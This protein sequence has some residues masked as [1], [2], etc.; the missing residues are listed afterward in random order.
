MQD[1]REP[2][3][4]QGEGGPLE[5][6]EAKA[7]DYKQTADDSTFTGKDDTRITELEGKDPNEVGFDGTND[8]F[9]PLSQPIWRKWM[10]VMTVSSGAIC[11]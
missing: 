2:R 10:S 9:D 11:V 3:A 5:N 6:A 1:A 7:G 4:R 8:P